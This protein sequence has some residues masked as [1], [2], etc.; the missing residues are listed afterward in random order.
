MRIHIR[1]S[2]YSLNEENKKLREMYIITGTAINMH[3][4]ILLGV[5]SKLVLVSGDCDLGTTELKNF[6][7]NKVSTDKQKLFYFNG[8]TNILLSIINNCFLT[9]CLGSN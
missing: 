7:W 8:H 4:I 3:L 2:V 9:T 5:V 1:R 6:D